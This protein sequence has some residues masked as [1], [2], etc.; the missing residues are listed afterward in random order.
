MVWRVHVVLV[1]GEVELVAVRG[2]PLIVDALRLLVRQLLDLLLGL[3]VLVEPVEDLA[4]HLLDPV[5]TVGASCV[6][7]HDVDLVRGLHIDVFADSER[8]LVL[9][10]FNDLFRRHTAQPGDSLRR[11]TLG[12]ALLLSFVG[13]CLCDSLAL[14]LF[15]ALA[16]R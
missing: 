8:L 7:V 9:V 13:G 2:H 12:H 15:L 16:I 4:L 6:L 10:L 1:A 11:T 3:G 5:E 14:L